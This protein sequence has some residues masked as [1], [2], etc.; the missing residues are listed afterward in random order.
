MSQPSSDPRIATARLSMLILDAPHPCESTT[1]GP[2]ASSPR[3]SHTGNTNPSFE[4]DHDSYA[5]G[6]GAI[7]EG[8]PGTL[9]ATAHA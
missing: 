1:T 6:P 4:N 5:I 7:S 9:R 3:A 2:S 8:S